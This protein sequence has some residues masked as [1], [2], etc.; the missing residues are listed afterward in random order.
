MSEASKELAFVG[1]TSIFV[2]HGPG[3]QLFFNKA[4]VL[5]VKHC[6][7]EKLVFI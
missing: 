5:R 2:F 1:R 3:D 4:L 7:V 6:N